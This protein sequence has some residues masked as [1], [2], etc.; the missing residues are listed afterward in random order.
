MSHSVQPVSDRLMKA[1]DLYR[2]AMERTPRSATEKPDPKPFLS[3]LTE[4]ESAEFLSQIADANSN[5]TGDRRSITLDSNAPPR[6]TDSRDT[7]TLDSDPF[8]TPDNDDPVPRTKRP[9]EYQT[10]GFGEFELS[11]RTSRRSADGAHVDRLDDYELLNEIGH[12]GMGVVYRARQKALNRIVALKMVLAGIRASK[13]QL[14]RFTAEAKAVAKLDHPNIVQVYDIDDHD[15][16]PF[17]AME[18]V[19]GGALDTLL[20]KQSLEPRDA[21]RLVETV[22]RA[23]AYA[24]SKGVIHRDL[25]PANIL[26]A[27]HAADSRASTKSGTGPSSLL[28]TVTP[29][30][31]DFGLAKQLDD[32]GDPVTRSGAV[33][34]TPHYMAPEQAEGNTKSVTHLADVYSLGATLYELITGRPPF[35][36]PSIVNILSQVRASDP[37]HPSRLQPG[38]PRDL[39]TI[40]LKAMQKEPA[41]RYESAEAMADDLK[42]FLDGQPILARPIGSVEQ[43]VRW[44]RRKPA[45]AG[46]TVSTAVLALALLGGGVVYATDLQQKNAV[47]QKQNH[48]LETMNVA[49]EVS[50]TALAK[51][52]TEVQKQAESNADKVRFLLRNTAQDLKTV[53]LNK[54]RENLVGFLM[55]DLKRIEGLPGDNAGVDDRARL[56]VNLNLADIYFDNALGAGGDRDKQKEFLAKSEEEYRKAV[57]LAESM[58][59]AK[60]TS[61]LANG[62][63][64]LALAQRGEFALQT[65]KAID[66]AV[67]FDKAFRLRKAIVDTPQ[68]QPGTRDYLFEAD[69]LSSLAESYRNLCDHPDTAKDAKKAADALREMVSLNEKALKTVEAD[70]KTTEEP[71]GAVMFRRRL[72]AA[73]AY[74]ARKVKGDEA[75][76]YLEKARIVR[77]K[78]CADVPDSIQDRV[79]L[80]ETV[81]KLG[82]SALFSN[83]AK[84]AGTLYEAMLNH[85]GK[86]V[87]PVDTRRQWGMAYYRI[88]TAQL[89]AGEKEKAVRTYRK[90]ANVWE[91]LTKETGLPREYWGLMVALA[92]CGEVDQALTL[93]NDVVEKFKNQVDTPY[94]AA[95]AYSICAGAIGDGQP[96]DKLTPEQLKKRMECLDNAWAKLTKSIELKRKVNDIP[97]DPDLAY[98]RSR[99]DFAKKFAEAK[100]PAKK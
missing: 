4:V 85:L 71:T 40:C 62:L 83:D 27:G 93:T 31:T 82:D 35:Q 30:V 59:A 63:W 77:E 52:K 56:G 61:D 97:T 96:D 10:A 76:A 38:I 90:S 89:M 22:T 57:T 81:G 25:K 42:R 55:S 11:E 9:D 95:C 94:N 74:A 84:T 5:G 17:F 8:R 26:L 3:G 98:L 37:V 46:L 7:T 91:E 16:L 23:M 68:S 51:E 54:Q 88:A 14:T 99:P 87:S 20:K 78:V 72:G 2:Q 6:E 13:T 60:P 66:A 44:C 48:D 53:G 19:D 65:G 1:I 36:G 45:Q 100:L 41:K 49:L 21:A 92:R 12:G 50:N 79:A 80:S 29:K 15:G 24:H 43:F 75:K 47:I 28:S 33:M 39:E 86:A 32:D 70:P 18:F 67:D 64:A 58:A 69:R 34:G 73:Y